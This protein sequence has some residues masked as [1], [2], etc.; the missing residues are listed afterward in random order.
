MSGTYKIRV[1]EETR[2]ALHDMGKKGESYDDVIRR[3]LLIRREY[4]ET[5][6]LKE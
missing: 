1:S 4:E 2:R 5:G 6:G 3:L